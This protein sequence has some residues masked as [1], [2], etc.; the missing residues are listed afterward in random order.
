MQALCSCVQSVDFCRAVLFRKPEN[1]STHSVHRLML[2]LT[3]TQQ[4]AHD[5]DNSN[6]KNNNKDDDDDN[7]NNNNKNNM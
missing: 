7:N 3:G 1:T 2:F 4:V 6:N 5:D